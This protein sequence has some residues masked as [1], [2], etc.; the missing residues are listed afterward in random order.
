MNGGHDFSIALAAVSLL[1]ALAFIAGDLWVRRA[2]VTVA[3]GL[4]FVLLFSLFA[5]C[6]PSQPYGPVLAQLV[7]V[8]GG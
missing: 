7:E 4:A 6:S 3:C 2:S 5:G 8:H 1:L